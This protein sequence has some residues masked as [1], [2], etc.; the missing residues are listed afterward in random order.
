MPHV[1]LVLAIIA[2][3]LVMLQAPAHAEDAVFPPGSRVGLVPLIGLSPAKTFPGFETADQ[4][5]KVLVTE[6]PAAAY[7]EVQGAFKGADPTTG[8]GPKPQ[9]VET[10]SGTAYY[11]VENAKD[12]SGDVRRYSMILSGG[13][14]S[15]YVAVQVPENAG[16]IYSDDAVRQMFASAVVR[17][18]V[19]VSEQLALMPFN[20]SDRADFK[21]VRTLSLGA[22][23]LLADNEESA[24]LE[25]A[26]YML[27]GLIA[28]TAAQ[29]ED[30]GRFAQQIATTIP[31][32]RE[33]RVTMSEPIRID[34][35][36][37]YET[38]IDA[39]SGKDNTPVTVVQW[40]RFG[41][42]NSLRMIGSAPRDQ[43]SAAFPRFRAV[44]DGI[45]PRG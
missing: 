19:P 22:A 10:A 2:A 33:A 23:L 5:V 11:T 12:A 9:S 27:V 28:S 31:G 30:R 35:M 17:K 40:L 15:G 26:P 36:P 25:T 29:P 45:K 43:W 7:G 6:L 20:V 24:G 8:P 4:G 37:G 42:E 13:T 18:E 21:H 16:K 3:W 38:R 44:R 32:I 14:F 39:I 34:G 41:S 1:R